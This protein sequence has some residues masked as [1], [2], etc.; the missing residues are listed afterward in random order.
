MF[1][2]TS[3]KNRNDTQIRLVSGKWIGYNAHVMSSKYDVIYS[4][5]K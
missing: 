2:T 3:Y 5:T 1:F 4:G